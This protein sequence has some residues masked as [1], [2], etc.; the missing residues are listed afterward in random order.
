MPRLPGDVGTPVTKRP[1]VPNLVK[2]VVPRVTVQA[3]SANLAL[4]R[5]GL[6]PGTDAARRREFYQGTN[7]PTLAEI[8]TPWIESLS[9]P[10]G[11]GQW[12]VR[13]RGPAIVQQRQQ[14]RAALTAL[15]TPYATGTMGTPLY[16]QQQAAL[17]A[18]AMPSAMTTV[19]TPAYEARQA[20]LRAWATPYAAGTIGTPAYN[21]RPEKYTST[22]TTNPTY[23]APNFSNTPTKIYQGG[24]GGGGGGGGA[25]PV[26]GQLINWRIGY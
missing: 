23:Q 3:S 17:R 2:P 11:Q 13:Q 22:I 25:G 20:A 24:W 7:P 21:K 4:Q 16:E 15:A 8:V 5:Q 19:G 1:P 18:R 14:E 26:G 9:L 6:G 12:A 10:E